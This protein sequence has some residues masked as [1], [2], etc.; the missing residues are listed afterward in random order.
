MIMIHKKKEG[1]LIVDSR[2]AAVRY[3][4]RWES[5]KYR[6]FGIKPEM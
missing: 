2:T 3:M 4:S 1:F 6:V 5:I